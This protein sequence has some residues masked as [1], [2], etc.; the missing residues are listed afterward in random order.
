M[1]AAGVGEIG[2]PRETEQT[3]DEIIE[4]GE[5]APGVPAGQARAIFVKRDVAAVMQAVFDAPV[6]ADQREQTP[7]GCL[8]AGQARQ[9]IDDLMVVFPVLSSTRSRCS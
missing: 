1:G 6:G 5:D 2:R 8:R 9:P 7:S 3:D 4:G